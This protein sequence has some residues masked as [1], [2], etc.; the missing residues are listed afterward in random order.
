VKAVLRRSEASR[1]V[2][3]T[4]ILEVGEI[5]MDPTRRKAVV[6][7]EQVHLPLKQYNLLKALMINKDRVLGREELFHKVWDA[8]VAYDTGSL[9]V[10]IRWLRERI[11]ADPS[12][13]RYIRT[14]R[15]I[16]YRIIDGSES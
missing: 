9:D 14:V 15:G 12:R 13:P 6:R 3:E 7:G 1:I 8:E 2:E 11:E 5:L 16:G 10:H 4:A